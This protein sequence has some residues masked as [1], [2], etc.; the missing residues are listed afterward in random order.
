MLIGIG[1]RL[2]IAII[3]VCITAAVIAFRSELVEALG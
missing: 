1:L 3:I 2:L